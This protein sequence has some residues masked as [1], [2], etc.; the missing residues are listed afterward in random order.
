MFLGT[1]NADGKA[2]IQETPKDNAVKTEQNDG[3]DDPDPKKLTLRE[4]FNVVVMTGSYHIGDRTYNTATPFRV[5]QQ[6]Q[7]GPQGQLLLMPVVTGGVETHKYN[8][9]NPGVGVEFRINKY[10]HTGAG[11]YKNSIHQTSV[12]ALLGT[13]TSRSKFLGAGMEVGAVTGY[14]KPIIPSAVGYVRLGREDQA[15]NVKIG[16]I[17]PIKDVTPAVVTAQVRVNLDALFKPK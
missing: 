6:A 12:Y 8:E 17:P 16:G 1:L 13:E 7:L 11:V 3:G 5:I 2:T 14:F 9:F 10:L 15:V 4:R